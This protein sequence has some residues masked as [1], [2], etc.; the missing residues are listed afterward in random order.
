VPVR[1]EVLM[2]TFVTMEV[3]AADEARDAAREQ[4]A[5]GAIARAFEWFRAIERCCTRF[6]S[7]SELMRL[8]ARPGVAVPVSDILFEAVRFAIAV[9]E[10]SGCA[11]DPT[12]GA[13]MA[14]RGFDR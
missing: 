10:D 3:C 8:C 6:E 11:F 5:A 12:V 14:A 4:D 13:A 2:G 1:T 7:D 9:A